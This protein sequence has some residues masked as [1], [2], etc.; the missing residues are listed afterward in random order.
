MIFVVKVG[1]SLFDLPDLGPR[2]QRWLAKRT[3]EHIVLVPGGGA[4]ADVVRAWDLHHQLGDERSHWLALRAMTLNAYLLAD[5]LGGVPLLQGV[6][7][8]E[9]SIVVLDAY[10][11]IR[12]DEGR[13]GCLPHTWGVT[14][15]AVAA[16]VGVV[17]GADRLVLLKS[18][19][20]GADDFVDAYFAS[21]V[22]QARG[23]Q[24]QAVN[25]RAELA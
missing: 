18:T 24:V 14:S 2:L 5:L 25:F 17:A 9:H 4:T 15:D 22:A 8:L 7:R 1:G 21:I 16:R 12:R 20:Q 6:E 23:L 10:E 3:E 19:D 13:S 11:F